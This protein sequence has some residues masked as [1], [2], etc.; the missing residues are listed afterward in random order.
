[1]KQ[2]NVWSSTLP[3]KA[4][5]RAHVQRKEHR[6]VTSQF[7]FL[8]W[9]FYQKNMGKSG[10]QA[11]RVGSDKSLN[12]QQVGRGGPK[13][14]WTCCQSHICKLKIQC[15]LCIVVTQTR[16]AFMT[17]ICWTTMLLMTLTQVTIQHINSN[18]NNSC[19]DNDSKACLAHMYQ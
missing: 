5:S 11:D 17:E 2:H 4:S 9:F 19:V 15:A 16:C 18:K 10:N 13:T 12:V 6:C 3:S 8:I 14:N 7:F 1:M